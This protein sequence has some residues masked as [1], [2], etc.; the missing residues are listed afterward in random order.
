VIITASVKKAVQDA[1]ELG[2]EGPTPDHTSRH[3]AVLAEIQ[4]RLSAGD[5]R[6]A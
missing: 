3:R 2:N 4:M 6:K 5:H 1:M